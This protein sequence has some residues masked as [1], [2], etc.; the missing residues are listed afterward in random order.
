MT[1]HKAPLLSLEAHGTISDTLTY[2]GR[3]NRQIARSKPTLP[4]FLTLPTRYQ[5]WL[6]QD[7]AYLW[8]QQTTATKQ[9]YATAGNPHHLTAFQYWM[10]YQL[11]TLPDLLGYWKLDANTG[12]TTP[13]SSRNA[14]TGTIFGA[15][16]ATGR[17]DGCLTF[18]GVN[19]YVAIPFAT[20]PQFGPTSSF[21]VMCHARGELTNDP[22]A[23]LVMRHWGGAGF[24]FRATLDKITLVLW[25]GVNAASP[26]SPTT[27]CDDGQ[28]HH[29]TGVRNKTTGRVHI[30]LDG[31]DVN[32][33]ADPTGDLTCTNP[34]EIGR[35]AAVV[36][37]GQID[38]AI[39]FNRV[40]DP[41]EIARHAARRWPPQ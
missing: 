6:Y 27:P 39:L 26:T 4:Y 3:A 35:G 29:Y 16:P 20:I 23:P 31:I 5:R 40:L 22:S 12:P 8:N 41:T 11:T 1:K 36:W 33:V 32:N 7:Y 25:D 30:Y 34:V 2:Q 14:A 18:D 13:D 15:S 9:I 37:Q 10:K 28:W 19:D 38:H 17:I 21:T 24:N